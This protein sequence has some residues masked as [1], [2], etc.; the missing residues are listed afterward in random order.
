MNKGYEHSGLT[1]N[2]MPCA[3]KDVQGFHL[4][5]E[6]LQKGGQIRFQMQRGGL[7]SPGS[8]LHPHSAAS[9][10]TWLPSVEGSAAF[11]RPVPVI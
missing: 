2:C 10:N 11:Q 9:S 8:Q 6:P 5:I 7:P 1:Y 3:T 4:S